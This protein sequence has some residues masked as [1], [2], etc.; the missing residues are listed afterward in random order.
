MKGL[1]WFLPLLV[2]AVSGYGVYYILNHQPETKR[3]HQRSQQFVSVEGTRLLP[4]DFQVQLDSYGVVRPRTQSQLISQVAGKI[5]EISDK[6]REGSFFEAGE[7]LVR[8]DARDYQAELN[9]AKA[10]L[11]QA[12]LGLKQERARAEQALRDWK[13]LGKGIAGELVLRKPQVAAAEA[14]IASAQARLV[15]AKLNMERTRITAPYSGRVLTK[16]VDLGQVVASGTPLADLFAVDYV[17]VRLPLN[18]RQLEYIQLPEQ[19]R[20]GELSHDNL[21]EVSLEARIGRHRYHWSG[22]VIRV[23]G[24][25]DEDSRQLFVVAQ[26]EDPYSL[27]PQGNPPLKIGQ[28]VKARIKGRLLKDVF[29]F[30]RI[31]L[32]QDNSILLIH[33]GQ[34]QH[35]LIQP[36]WM[37]KDSVVVRE[38]IEPGSLLNLTPMGTGANGIAVRAIID[39][40]PIA[41]QSG[42]SNR[43]DKTPTPN[44]KDRVKPDGAQRQPEV[45]R[46][47]AIAG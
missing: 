45:V 36:V 16:Q 6:F 31:A 43:I 19:Y 8:I 30:S 15:S 1:R 5:V 3:A 10:E 4:R 26:I 37:D 34:L 20:G 25:I 27:N 14:T 22:K 33:N 9:I 39:G 32:S 18:S 24:A 21:P 41:G 11:V 28:F 7:E 13:R 46:S 12:Q 35:R 44:T 47:Q 17:E 38:G 42:P 40:E 2:L 23:E 29:V